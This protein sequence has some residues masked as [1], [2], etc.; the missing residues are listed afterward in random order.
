MCGIWILFSVSLNEYLHLFP[1]HG[2]WE[3]LSWGS[4]CSWP[5]QATHG[6][7]KLS[8]HPG[9]RHVTPTP[10]PSSSN[11]ITPL[12]HEYAGSLMSF[13]NRVRMLFGQGTVTVCVLFNEGRGFVNCRHLHRYQMVWGLLS[14][15]AGQLFEINQCRVRALPCWT[16]T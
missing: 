10:A 9:P 6:R 1:Y 11:T 7:G 15:P 5:E 4:P 3:S 8:L 12:P 14:L 2:G 13:F 16:T